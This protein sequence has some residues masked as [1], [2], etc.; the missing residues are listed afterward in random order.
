LISGKNI[1]IIYFSKISKGSN[2]SPVGF[3]EGIYVKPDYQKRL[4]AENY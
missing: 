3:V 2:S 1:N 4:S